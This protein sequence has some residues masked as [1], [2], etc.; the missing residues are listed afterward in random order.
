M[1]ATPPSAAVRAESFRNRDSSFPLFTAVAVAAAVENHLDPAVKVE[2][3]SRF[4]WL[5]ISSNSLANGVIWGVKLGFMKGE[6]VPSFRKISQ[7]RVNTTTHGASKPSLC[8]CVFL[9]VLDFESE[10]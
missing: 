7:C 1:S 8:F 2:V 6:Q 5:A 9:D 3:T 10:K 4:A